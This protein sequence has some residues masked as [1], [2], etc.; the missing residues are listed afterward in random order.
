MV[1]ESET[2]ICYIESSLHR[3][4]GMSAP[5]CLTP[6]ALMGQQR[7]VICHHSQKWACAAG[8]GGCSPL[9]WLTGYGHQHQSHNWERGHLHA[10]IQENSGRH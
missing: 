4:W 10:S 1:E 9:P 8:P 5:K 3:L 7:E 6:K 2:W